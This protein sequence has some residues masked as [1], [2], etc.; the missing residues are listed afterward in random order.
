MAAATNNNPTTVHIQGVNRLAQLENE[1][2]NL[3][4]HNSRLYGKKAAR[5]HCLFAGC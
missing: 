3:R 5:G 2:K 4:H 1:N